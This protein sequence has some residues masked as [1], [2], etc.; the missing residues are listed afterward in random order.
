MKQIFSLAVI[1]IFLSYSFSVS[2]KDLSA[3]KIFISDD[4]NKDC[5]QITDN[6]YDPIRGCYQSNQIY[7]SSN[8]PLSHLPFV[9]FHEIGH[10]L[11]EE[12]DFASSDRDPNS[13]KIYKKYINPVPQKLLDQRISEIAADNFALWM[14][15][16]RYS[17]K[18]EK[19]FIDL[20]IK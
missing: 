2:A 18:M 6:T 14:L 19:F 9:F 12:I 8:I 4:I 17:D 11:M 1:L 10:Y 16:A 7:I 15:G 13:E 3:L 5:L 20:L